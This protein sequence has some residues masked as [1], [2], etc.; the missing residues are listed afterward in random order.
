MRTR[1]VWGHGLGVACSRSRT[2]H[3]CGYVRKCIVR[4]HGL[5]KFA[6]CAWVL[7]ALTSTT[8]QAFVGNDLAA[9]RPCTEIPR[10]WLGCC[11]AT[12]RTLAGRCPVAAWKTARKC[13]RQLRGHLLGHYSGHFAGHCT[14]IARLAA[15]PWCKGM[16]SN[17]NTGFPIPESRHRFRSTERHK[18]QH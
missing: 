7:P 9:P 2:G 6:D 12:A 1:T 8:T 16:V 15:L 18:I 3:D 4:V 11:P 10:C 17:Q 13:H 5:T 14:A